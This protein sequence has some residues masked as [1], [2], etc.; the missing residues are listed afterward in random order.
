LAP[1]AELRGIS[2][3]NHLAWLTRLSGSTELKS[4]FSS[5]ANPLGADRL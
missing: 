2:S 5:L 1:R 3:A 4:A